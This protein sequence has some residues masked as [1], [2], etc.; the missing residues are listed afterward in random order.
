MLP[1]EKK[2]IYLGAFLGAI[3]ATF[4]GLRYYG[5]YGNAYA[6]N[7]N[8]DYW[9]Q[10]SRYL[11]IFGKYFQYALASFTLLHIL[12]NTSRFDVKSAVMFFLCVNYF[13]PAYLGLVSI[14]WIN[15]YFASSYAHGLQ[16]MVFLFFHSYYAR[17]SMQA[18]SQRSGMSIISACRYIIIFVLLCLLAG[19]ILIWHKV[20]PP[21]HFD[22]KTSDAY[23]MSLLTALATGMLVTH[24]WFDSFFWKFTN[25]ESR[26][27]ILERYNF[28]FKT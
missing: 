4:L 6:N 28:L 12:R 5:G 16:Y 18:S 2:L 20:I 8:F 3:S 26:N 1:I 22:D 9:D 23:W 15:F 25:K 24:F 21:L 17:H 19:E 7:V 14:K 27:W 11:G 10:M 13:L